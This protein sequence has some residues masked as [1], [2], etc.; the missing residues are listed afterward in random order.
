MERGGSVCVYSGI[1]DYFC[2]CFFCRF[3]LL[4]YPSLFVLRRSHRSDVIGC[5]ICK[6]CPIHGGLRG[7]TP[8]QCWNIAFLALIL[9]VLYSTGWICIRVSLCVQYR[10]SLVFSVLSLIFMCLQNEG[11]AKRRESSRTWAARQLQG[12]PPARVGRS[13]PLWCQGGQS[14]YLL[15]Q[16]STPIRISRCT[17]RRSSCSAGV[18]YWRRYREGSTLGVF[19]RAAEGGRWWARQTWSWVVDSD[20]I[21]GRTG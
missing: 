12:P 20:M 21:R 1:Y 19:A 14:A 9:C 4:C 8:T 16:V 18:P 11:G 6:R 10:F 17:H 7:P 3:S 2:A 13:Q 15:T 5:A